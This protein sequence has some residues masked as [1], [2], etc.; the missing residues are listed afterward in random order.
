[1]GKASGGLVTFGEDKDAH[2]SLGL[3]LRSGLW[4]LVYMS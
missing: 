1:M 4:V 2:P 3:G